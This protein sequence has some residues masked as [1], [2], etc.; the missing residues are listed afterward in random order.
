MHP[1]REEPSHA[2][3]ECGDHRRDA[4][5][6]EQAIEERVFGAHVDRAEDLA[7]LHDTLEDDE[8]SALDARAIGLGQRREFAL[9][10]VRVRGEEAAARVVDRRGENERAV[11]QQCQVLAR[12][13]G[14]VEAQRRRRR[15]SEELGLRLQVVDPPPVVK[16]EV[17]GEHRRDREQHRD[18]RSREL[19]REDLAADRAV[20]AGHG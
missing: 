19:D 6:T 18:E 5:V 14:V 15:L 17:V 9:P 2:H 3:G 4:E 13:L 8:L 1:A 11:A 12:R 7:V 20:G 16:A 10:L